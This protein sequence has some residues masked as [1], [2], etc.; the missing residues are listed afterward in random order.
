[1]SSLYILIVQWYISRRHG[2]VSG[3]GLHHFLQECQ[4]V[5]MRYQIVLLHGAK[6][7]CYSS[8]CRQ[9]CKSFLIYA[10]GNKQSHALLSLYI[11]YIR[12]E[13]YITEPTWKSHF[14]ENVP[15]WDFALI[16][17]NHLG[18]FIIPSD[19]SLWCIRNNAWQ[20]PRLVRERKPSP[21]WLEYPPK[22]HVHEPWRQ[23]NKNIG[24]TLYYFR[25][26]KKGC[27]P[28]KDGLQPFIPYYI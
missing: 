25:K 16:I 19:T 3:V 27:N 4:P 21:S 5:E 20:T 14:Y 11:R 1:M 15:F 13:K 28:R 2:W 9:S 6:L 23:G 18:S 10:S 12:F 8:S 22:S 17:I 7:V 26:Q 24:I